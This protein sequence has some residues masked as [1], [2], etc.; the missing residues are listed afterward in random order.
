MQETDLNPEARACSHGR[1]LFVAAFLVY[2]L[3]SSGNLPGDTAVRWDVARSI[4]GHGWF[5]IPAGST[6]LAT[7]GVDGRMYSMYGLG[8][9]LCL[10]PF[11]WAGQLAG[12]L[13][14]LDADMLGQFLA[15]LILFPLIGAACVWMLYRVAMDAGAGTRASLWLAGLYALGTS[16]WHNSVNTYEESQI[17]LCLLVAVWAMQRYWNSG[18]AAYLL[19]VFAAMGVGLLF[20]LS[21]AVV[22]LAVGLVGIGVDL[23]RADVAPSRPARFARWVLCGLAAMGPFLAAVGWYNFARFGRVAETGYGPVHAAMGIQLFATPFWQGLGGLLVSPG[24]SVFLYVPILIAAAVGLPRF[25]PAHRRLAM[26]SIAAFAASV[27]F[28]ATYTFWAGDLAWGPRYLAS[29]MPLA[30]LPILPLL[31]RPRISRW[32]LTVAAVS[33]LVQVA[34][35]TYSFGLEY[36]Q[37]RRHGTIPDDYVWRVD[38]SQLVNRFKNIGLHLAGRPNYQSIPPRQERPETCQVVTTPAQVA[39][40]HAVNFFPFKALAVTKNSRLFLMS[41]GMWLVALAV[42]AATIVLW[43]R[44]ARHRPGGQTAISGST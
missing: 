38:E 14:H 41:L 28:H 15:S 12:R 22:F 32:V 6:L 19:A 13:T 17:A 37:D 30:I 5:D 20:R 44:Q 1:W 27:L 2:V 35:V 3:T 4:A 34:S 42:L 39:Q 33:V 10:V 9:S 23:A 29:I 40:I 16:H 8:Q 36:F 11:V 21:S 7:R 43:V 26:L 24:K 18:T 25:W 31:A